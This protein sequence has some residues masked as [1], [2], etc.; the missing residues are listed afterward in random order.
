MNQGWV[1]QERVGKAGVGQTLLA[2]YVQRY[3]HCSEADWRSRI[4][5]QQILLNDQPAQPDTLLER[6]D[7]LA[8]HPPPWQEPNAPLD[9]EILYED[10]D[11]VAVAKPSG[12]PVMPGAGF[13]EHTL[14]GQLRKRYPTETPVPI[15]RLGRGTSGLVLLG[16]SPLAK[17]GLTRQMRDR[18][19]HKVYL[20]LA[21]GVDMP[22]QFEI[23]T[24]IGKV[25]HPTLG[26][27]YGAVAD[28]DPSA[29]FAHSQCQ[30]LRRDAEATLLQVTILTGRPHQIRI[31]L[32]AA[33]YP[34][35]GDP[36]YAVGGLPKLTPNPATGTLP[37]PGDCGYRLHAWQ[38]GCTH[39]RSSQPITLTA[40]P[41]DVLEWDQRHDSL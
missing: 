33:G 30:A 16:R 25:S 4:L 7:Q 21:E 5:S 32:A 31:H 12:L 22:D 38:L 14:L 36:L 18:K 39:P 13:L 19:I 29:R 34:L 26:Y 40:P 15:H 28:D 3:R 1:Y 11:L 37:V 27:I 41:P 8:Y 10:A 35:V 24:A 6:G 17:A 9:F 2:Y 20:A 23:T